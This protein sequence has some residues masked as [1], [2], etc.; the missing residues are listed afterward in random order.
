MGVALFPLLLWLAYGVIGAPVLHRWHLVP[1]SLLLTLLG[2][3]A[4]SEAPSPLPSGAKRLVGGTLALAVCVWLPSATRAEKSSLVDTGYYVGR[5][6]AYREMAD[7]IVANDAADLELL[8]LEP[9]YLCF[10]TGN[11]AIDLGGLVTPGLHFHDPRDRR[12]RVVDVVARR[13][14]PL[15]VTSFGHPPGLGLPGYIIVYESFPGR[16]LLMRE[17]VYRSRFDALAARRLR[18]SEPP[19]GGAAAPLRVGYGSVDHTGG[20]AVGGR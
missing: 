3:L 20:G 12:S 16:Q 19:R 14:P 10:L 8:T 6:K 15:V 4:G 9:G 18:P 17:S 2:F 5:V 7:W 1:A 13:E 11:P